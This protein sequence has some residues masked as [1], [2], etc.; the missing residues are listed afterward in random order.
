MTKY[1]C[2]VCGYEELPDPPENHDICPCCLV[3]FE[4][5]DHDPENYRKWWVADGMRFRSRAIPPPKD[6]DPV[7]QLEKFKT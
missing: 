4:Y 1:T 2:F 5:D 3:E 6:W 7:K